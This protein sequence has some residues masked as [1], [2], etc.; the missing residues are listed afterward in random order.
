MRPR[1]AIASRVRAASRRAAKATW[2]LDVE[3]RAHAGTVRVV[4]RV[5]VNAGG[6]WVADVLTD[7][8]AEPPTQSAWSRAA[9]S[10]S[11]RLFDHDRAYI[12]QNADGRVSSPSPM[13]ATYADRHDQRGLSRRSEIFVANWGD[14]LP[15]VVGWP[16]NLQPTTVGSRSPRRLSSPRPDR[17]R[18]P[19]RSCRSA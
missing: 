15:T 6:P 4:P 13:S 11:D 2:R 10:S 8:P 18:S 3:D 17:R 5:L 7:V 19:R 16:W 12:F 14:W 9:T 1:G